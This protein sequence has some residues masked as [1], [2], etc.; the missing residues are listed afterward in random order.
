MTQRTHD[1]QPFD[2]ERWADSVAGRTL[3]LTAPTPGVDEPGREEPGLRPP[4]PGE[5]G[6]C[7]EEVLLVGTDRN[8]PGH[9]PNCGF[10]PGSER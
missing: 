7:G 2:R 3:L 4:E 8:E 5:C 9:C 1:H 10:E 6:L